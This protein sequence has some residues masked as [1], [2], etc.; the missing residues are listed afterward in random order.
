MNEKEKNITKG[1]SDLLITDVFMKHGIEQ[2]KRNL[3]PEQKEQIRSLV[4]DL[5]NQV[6]Q[7]LHKTSQTP[8]TVVHNASKAG[9]TPAPEKSIEPTRPRRRLTFKRNGEGSESN[10]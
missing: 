8:P 4:E 5:Q 2:K 10:D 7:F 3:T 6:E 9:G 1:L